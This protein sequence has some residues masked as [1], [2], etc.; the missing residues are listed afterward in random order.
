[1]LSFPNAKINTGLYVTKKRADGYHNLESI[2]LPVPLYDIL[3]IVPSDKPSRLCITGLD[4][5]GIKEENLVFKAW[6]LLH[7]DFGLPGVKINL[8][9]LIPTGSGLGGGSAD[10]AGCLLNLNKQF[11]LALTENE[12]IDYALKLGSDCPFFIKN[13]PVVAYGRGEIM[14]EIPLDLSGN[15]ILLVFP[16]I[17][18][19]TAEAFKDIEP[20][21]AGF[22]LKQLPSLPQQEWK[23][24]IQ[25]DFEKLIC[26]KYPTLADIKNKMYD[27]GAWYA[28]MSGS[29]STIYGL[30][31]GKPDL[32]TNFAG[33]T[34]KL[35]YYS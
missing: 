16:G 6:K 9:K 10:A 8:H 23:H 17:H 25:N 24:R 30:F 15:F 14:E 11:N 12:L 29:G 31:T 34:Y 13:K 28:Q 4:V 2:F 35:L 33:M 18:V 27:S 32:K 3:E 22:D 26:K 7:E 19:S 1:M 5:D 21:K 20:K